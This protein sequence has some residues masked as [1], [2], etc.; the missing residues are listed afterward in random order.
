MDWPQ[1]RRRNRF[2]HHQALGLCLLGGA[3]AVPHLCFQSSNALIVRRDWSGVP[4]AIIHDPGQTSTAAIGGM[5]AWAFRCRKTWRDFDANRHGPVADRSRRFVLHRFG[6]LGRQ[7]MPDLA[8]AQ[9]ALEQLPAYVEGLGPSGPP[10]FFVVFVALECLSLPASP[11]L[12]SSGYLFGLPLGCAIS[13]LSLC[14]AA[15]ISFWLAR[16]IFKPQL[17]K[18][19]EENEAFQDINCAVQAEGFKIIFLLRLA[20]L[21]PFAISN[22]AYGLTT[23]GFLEFLLATLFGCA[24]GTCSFVYFATIARDAGGEGTGSPWYVYA[25]GIVATVVLLKIVKDVAQKAVSDSIAA[26][27]RDCVVDEACLD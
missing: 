16:T 9:A 15:S 18:L 25:G 1:K 27:R 17:T 13:L 4:E 3:I 19:A 23:V 24:P 2:R 10:L 8:S 6:K 11:L 20:P 12:L 22:Y 21:L 5:G 7:A 14:T 26:D